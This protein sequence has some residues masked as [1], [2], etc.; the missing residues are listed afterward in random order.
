LDR[1]HARQVLA[2][3]SCVLPFAIVDDYGWYSIPIVAIVVFTLY[4][5]EG[6][7]S[8]LEDPF[9][10]DKNDIKMDGIVEDAR[11]ELVVLLEEWVGS[12]EGREMDGEGVGRGAGRL[13]D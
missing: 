5:I 1:I 10:Y 8:Q 4:G 2:L 13:F 6:I 9:G 11:L 3:F 7:G 12:V